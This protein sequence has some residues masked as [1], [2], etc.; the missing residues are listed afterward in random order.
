MEHQLGLLLRHRFGPRRERVDP[1]QLRLFAEDAA[2]DVAEVTPEEAPGPEAARTKRHWR[3]KGQQRLPE[4]LPRERAEYPLSDAELPCPDRG[5]PRTKDR[6]GDGRATGVRALLAFRCR[7]R[8]V[9]VRLPACQ[10]HVVLAEKPPQPIERGLTGPGLLA[11]TITSKFSDHLPLYRLEDIFARH[12]VAL[13]RA[14]LC[15]WM[16]SCA[17]LLTPLYDLKATGPR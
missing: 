17:E 13:P 8:A 11:Q 4:D 1:D 5:R 12:G 2:E 16:A 6:R 14:T 15:G 3:R 7:A 9:P 10:E